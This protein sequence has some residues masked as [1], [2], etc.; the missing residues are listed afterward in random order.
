MVSLQLSQFDQHPVIFHIADD[1]VVQ[2]V[3]AIAVEIQLLFELFVAFVFV[4]VIIIFHA[5][6]FFGGRLDLMMKRLLLIT[7]L[8]ISLTLACTRAASDSPSTALPEN[9][10]SPA[11]GST[12]LCQPADLQISSN[13]TGATGAL[14]LG[15]TLTNKSKNPCALANPPQA[16][17]LN[18]SAQPLDVQTSNTP[19]N[20]TPPAPAQMVLAPDESAIL[21]LVWRNYCQP[22]PNDSLTIHLELTSGQ[23]LEVVTSVLSVPRCDAKNEPST[24]A[25]APYSSPP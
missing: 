6:R 1:W 23:N 5:E 22:L 16:T 13:S 11:P 19:G 20:Q 12:P 17:L 8:T 4:H 2:N 21:T 7:L 10:P 14:V 9:F 15:M 18:G 24:V 3:I 25:V